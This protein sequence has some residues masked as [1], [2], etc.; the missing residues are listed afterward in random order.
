M[1]SQENHEN[2]NNTFYFLE[3]LIDNIFGY[4]LFNSLFPITFY[5]HQENR[6]EVH[7]F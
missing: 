2:Q 7:Y 1:W 3:K 4:K 6:L 5:L